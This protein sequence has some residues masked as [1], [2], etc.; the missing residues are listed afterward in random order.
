MAFTCGIQIELALGLSNDPANCQH[1][2]WNNLRAVLLT[3][4]AHS[5]LQR[6]EVLPS[7]AT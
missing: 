4:H 7:I 1:I 2:A 6:G 5:C 3:V